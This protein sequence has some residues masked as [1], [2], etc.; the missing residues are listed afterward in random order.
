MYNSFHFVIFFVPIF[1][2]CCL[3]K[4]VFFVCKFQAQFY[5]LILTSSHLCPFLF[6]IF[7]FPSNLPLSSLSNPVWDHCFCG[8]QKCENSFE[9]F[10]ADQRAWRQVKAA[11]DFFLDTPDP[12][13][14]ASPVGHLQAFN[15]STKKWKSQRLPGL[16]WAFLEENPRGQLCLGGLQG[17][18]WKDWRRIWKEN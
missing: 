15:A 18:A 5:P 16:P 2:D 7:T 3:K 13:A 6:L 10:S 17:G 12:K 9:I 11:L 1:L 4:I 8:R 14:V